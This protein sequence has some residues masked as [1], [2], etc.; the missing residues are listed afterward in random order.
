MKGN[1][2][3]S[4]IIDVPITGTFTLCYKKRFGFQN[5]EYE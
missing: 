1:I 5:N 4:K 2:I 3:K